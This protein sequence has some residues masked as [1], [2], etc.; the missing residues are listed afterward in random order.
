[1]D[2]HN[3]I[4]IVEAVCRGQQSAY[5]QLVRR[6]YD[7]VFL[8]CLGIV[9]N[10]HDAEDVSQEAM[11]KGLEKIRQLRARDQFGH[12]IVRIAR[13]LAINCLRRRSSADRLVRASREEP[14]GRDRATVDVHEA[15]ARLPLEL[16]QPL[17]MY[18]FDGR[19][20]KTV[21]E[22]LEI[23]TSGVYTK[24]RDALKELRDILTSQGDKS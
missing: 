3:D 21:A 23:S 9:G 18:Y 15:L 19:S 7:R 1:L 10:V 5:A 12:W 24:L 8:V 17:V 11:I 6:H 13:N 4:D 14:L 16:R 2:R 22:T 20:V